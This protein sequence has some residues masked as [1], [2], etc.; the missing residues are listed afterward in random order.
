MGA[1]DAPEDG[2]PDNRP[3]CGKIKSLSTVLYSS[4]QNVSFLSGPRLFG[5]QE[6]I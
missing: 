6:Y 4:E 2:E 1:E 3:E 5:T